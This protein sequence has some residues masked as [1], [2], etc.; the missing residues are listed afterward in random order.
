MVNLTGLVFNKRVLFCIYTAKEPCPRVHNNV[1]YYFGSE[2]NCKQLMWILSIGKIAKT[3]LQNL[4]RLLKRKSSEIID[5]KR[6]LERSGCK[7]CG[8]K[9]EPNETKAVTVHLLH[10][11]TQKIVVPASGDLVGRSTLSFLRMQIHLHFTFVHTFSNIIHTQLYMHVRVQ[12]MQTYTYL[13]LKAS[14]IFPSIH[15]S[16]HPSMSVCPSHCLTIYSFS[17]Y[18][19]IY[20]FIHLLIHLFTYFVYLFIYPSIHKKR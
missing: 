9:L 19:F 18:S 1:R 3:S 6:Q 20:L 17:I 12:H 15:P 2:N 14:S 4:E 16:V 8:C 7:L 11:L 13:N 10:I 5:L